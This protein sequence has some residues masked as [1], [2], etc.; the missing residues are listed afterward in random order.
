M[1]MAVLLSLMALFFAM[2][3]GSYIQGLSYREACAAHIR[4]NHEK[5][6]PQSLKRELS[7]EYSK[8]E[9]GFILTT[10]GGL[11]DELGIE[12]SGFYAAADY[13][14]FVTDTGSRFHRPLCPTVKL[15]LRP[16]AYKDALE[17]YTPC[18][19]CKP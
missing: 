18:A 7:L 9:S 4:L 14:C 12:D 2:I 19:V 11:S 17:K 3:Y 1:A 5:L 8:I 15:S 10:F 16:I 13:T 6:T